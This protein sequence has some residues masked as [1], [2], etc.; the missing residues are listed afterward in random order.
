MRKANRMPPARRKLVRVPWEV[1]HHVEALITLAQIRVFGYLEP[2]IG[3]HVNS[4]AESDQCFEAMERD[5][6]SVATR[7]NEAYNPDPDDMPPR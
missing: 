1:R 3:R 5:W 7:W 4:L 6:R 2:R